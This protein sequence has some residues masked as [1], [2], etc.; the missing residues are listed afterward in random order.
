VIV[1]RVSLID[2]YRAQFKRLLATAPYSALIASM[3][4]K[5]SD[6][7]VKAGTIEPAASAVSREVRPQGP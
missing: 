4:T 1:D 3:R 6:E 7:T 5:T 2:N